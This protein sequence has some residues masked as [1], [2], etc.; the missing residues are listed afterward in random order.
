MTAPVEHMYRVLTYRGLME[1]MARA[2][3]IDLKMAVMDG[4]IDQNQ[5]ERL[6]LRCAL[7]DQPDACS[8]LL[9]AR[10]NMET[11]PDFCVNSTSLAELRRRST[12][13]C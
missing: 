4:R 7:C 9:L 12:S 10:P 2:L 3:G 5:I 1:R 13:V 6:K 11:A 8:R